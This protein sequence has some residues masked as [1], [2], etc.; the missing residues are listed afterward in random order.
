MPKNYFITRIAEIRNVPTKHLPP[1]PQSKVQLSV[2]MP[3]YNAEQ[4][5][6]RAVRSILEQTHTNLEIIL[7]DDGSKD[8]TP[9][10]LDAWAKQDTRVRV[11]HQTNQGSSVSRR[12]G[13]EA[14]TSSLVTFVDADD[15]IH[16]EMYT[17][18]LR[19]MEIEHADMAI[20]G[21]CD[22][23]SGITPPTR[24]YFTETQG[25]MGTYGHLLRVRQGA[26]H[27]SV[28]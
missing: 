11:I 18:M 5:V 26:G 23:Y 19:G 16:P 24:L 4:Y 27:A 17:T 21:V 6:D 1:A 8:H 12:N 20:C 13:L 9:D 2:I 14:S 25:F 15:W 7:V 10:L 3:C 28:A 22:A